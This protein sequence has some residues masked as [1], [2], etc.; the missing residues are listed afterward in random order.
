MRRVKEGYEKPE[1]SS[2]WDA[3]KQKANA[4]MVNSSS[5]NSG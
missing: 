5:M 3:A 1:P 2:I 4:V